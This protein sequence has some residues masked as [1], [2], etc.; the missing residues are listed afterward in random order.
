MLLDWSLKRKKISNKGK[1]LKK[2]KAAGYFHDNV[3]STTSS[4][5]LQSN[6][7]VEQYREK[8]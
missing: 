7:G 8:A 5:L 4:A 3:L 2:E 6:A 1:C